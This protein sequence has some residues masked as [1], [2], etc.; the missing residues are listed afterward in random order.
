VRA[1]RALALAVAATASAAAA[2]DPAGAQALARFGP[3]ADALLEAHVNVQATPSRSRIVTTAPGAVMVASALLP[4]AG[5]ALLGEPRWF[6]FVAAEAWGWITYVDRRDAAR[7]LEQRYKDLAWSVARRVSVGERRDTAFEYYEA[8][9]QFEA[10]GAFDADPTRPGVQPETDVD[11]FNGDT[12]RLAR[13]LFLPGGVN[14]PETSVEYQRA[15]DY[16]MARAIPSGYAW[17]WG[18]GRLE[19]QRFNELIHASDEAF[20]DATFVIGAIIAN[21][22]ASAVDA[23]I[24]ARLSRAAGDALRVRQGFDARP[25]P[26]WRVTVSIPW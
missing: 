13:S 10:S 22:I 11:T 20:R 16:Y 23:L 2:S 24:A 21:H 17:S 12:W 4:G 26:R 7:D 5:Q 14:L 8:L 1:V 25:D 3:A 15:L 6:A 18:G 9:S 19:Q